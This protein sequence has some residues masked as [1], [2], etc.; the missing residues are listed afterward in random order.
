MKSQ[1]ARSFVS[2]VLFST[3]RY[4]GLTVKSLQNELKK[5]KL[6]VS[7]NKQA[8][9]HRLGANDHQIST[10]TTQFSK[11]VVSEEGKDVNAP[12][13]VPPSTVEGETTAP[14]QPLTSESSLTKSKVENLGAFTFIIPQPAR[15]VDTKKV[16]IPVL[17]TNWAATADTISAQSSSDVPKLSTASGISNINHNLYDLENELGDTVDISNSYLR[18]YLEKFTPKFEPAPKF[19]TITR[20]LSVDEKNG[21]VRALAVVAGLFALSYANQ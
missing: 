21:L 3:E 18:K 4:D 10:S 19:E 5:R 9:I 14:G 20:P 17:A 6:P 2:S 1:Q 12:P 13:E 8:L 11:R 15:I 16:K 7:G